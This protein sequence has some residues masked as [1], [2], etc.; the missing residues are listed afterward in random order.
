[1]EQAIQQITRALELDPNHARAHT[2][3][4]LALRSRGDLKAARD[5]FIRALEISPN[6]AEARRNLTEIENIIRKPD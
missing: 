3:L 1:L 5:Q 4:G 6:Y 2:N